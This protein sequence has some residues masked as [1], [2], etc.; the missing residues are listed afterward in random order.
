MVEQTYDLSKLYDEF[1]H[2]FLG[3][4]IEPKQSPKVSRAWKIKKVRDISTACKRLGY[5]K[6]KCSGMTWF[7]SWNRKKIVEK[8]VKSKSSQ[9]FS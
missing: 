2:D 1:S 6:T 3:E 9:L 7:A 8:L 5:M 4:Q